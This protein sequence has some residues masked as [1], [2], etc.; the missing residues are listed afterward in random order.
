M[1]T[2][3]RK[4]TQLLCLEVRS[5]A[6]LA[7]ENISV[8]ILG[9]NKPGTTGAQMLRFLPGFSVSVRLRVELTLVRGLRA[10]VRRMKRAACQP[11]MLTS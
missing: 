10:R 8:A 9:R 11:S 1:M 6:K 4:A 3:H 7:L 2:V 5:H